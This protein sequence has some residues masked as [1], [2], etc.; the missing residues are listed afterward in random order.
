MSIQ[1]EA[2]L[3]TNSPSENEQIDIQP[4]TIPVGSCPVCG[5]L[6]RQLAFRSPDRLHGTPGEFTYKRCLSCRTVFQDPRVTP[7][8]LEHCYPKEY[9]THAKVIQNTASPLSTAP[10]T[11]LRQIRNTIRHTIV[12]AVQGIPKRGLLGWIGR[13][14]A[15]S[16]VL[17]ERAFF[18]YLPDELI[19]RT[20]SKP[21]SLDVGCGAGAL[22]LALRRCG[23]EVEG[24][25]WDP[26]AANV[27]RETTGRTVF[28]GDFRKISLP[29]QT[30]D[31]IVLQHVFEHLDNSLAALQR[32]NDLLAPGGQAALFYP[33]PDSL[34]ARLFRDAWYPWDPP[35]HLV[36]P[37]AY[38]IVTALNDA[39]LTLISIRT[40]ARNAG[41]HF[42]NS[43]TFR[44]GNAI[45]PSPPQVTGWDRITA[46][47]EKALICFG[48]K[49]G[50]EL[51]VVFQKNRN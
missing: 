8:D 38:A 31:M 39:G 50:E 7:E 19:L 45:I 29:E 9:F 18:N 44:A 27:A 24:V 21:R 17:R 22:M 14:L 12:A 41:I 34:G 37:S 51:V 35:R 3:S 6:D 2:V 20:P 33:N 42:A 49:V 36:L 25:E 43:K 5:A 46:L 23:W 48:F 10:D 47:L 15:L 28:D 16:R 26:I 13:V 30:Y 40:T 32:I 1:V 4:R 11:G